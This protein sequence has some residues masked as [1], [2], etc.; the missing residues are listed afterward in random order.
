MD[1]DL[2]KSSNRLQSDKVL[3]LVVVGL[4]MVMDEFDGFDI[5]MMRSNNRSHRIVVVQLFLDKDN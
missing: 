1:Q 5:K 2:V 3:E 4:V